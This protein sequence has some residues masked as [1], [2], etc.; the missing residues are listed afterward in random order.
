MQHQYHYL[1]IEQREVLE[2]LIRSR[3]NSGA[4]LEASI[5]RLHRPD[6]GVCI[7][8]SRDIEFVRLQADPLAM[9]CRSCSRLPVSATA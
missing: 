3:I 8:C 6:Y 5:E 7:E 2:K 9:H 1:T 4:R